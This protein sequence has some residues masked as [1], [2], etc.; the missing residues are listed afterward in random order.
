MAIILDYLDGLNKATGILV[1]GGSQGEGHKRKGTTEAEVRKGK[2]GVWGERETKR[3]RK[4]GKGTTA[5]FQG[6]ERG[7]KP[8]DAA[9]RGPLEAGKARRQ[10]LPKS[11]HLHLSQVKPILNIQP[12]F[13]LLTSRSMLF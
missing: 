6:G 13:G 7:H 5:G 12:P 1:R 9:C 2:R 10:S 3:Q 4:I 8:R 11:R